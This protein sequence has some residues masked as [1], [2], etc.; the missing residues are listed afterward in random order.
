MRAWEREREG[1]DA[2]ASYLTAKAP[3]LGYARALASGW[4]IATGIG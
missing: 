1:A 2:C 3:Y 4:P